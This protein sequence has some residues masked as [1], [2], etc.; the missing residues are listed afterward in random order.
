MEWLSVSVS[1]IVKAIYAFTENWLVANSCPIQNPHH[2]KVMFDTC[3]IPSLQNV[4]SIVRCA[5]MTLNVMS[6]H[7]ASI[8]MHWRSVNVSMAKASCILNLKCWYYIDDREI[9]DEISHLPHCLFYFRVSS[10]LLPL[11]Q[12]HRVLWMYTRLLSERSSRMCPWV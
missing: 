8:S 4:Q 1:T 11:L 2:N 12:W 6:A 3:F 5:T 7:K 10:A 9:E